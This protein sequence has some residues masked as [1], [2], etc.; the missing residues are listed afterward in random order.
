M[1]HAE[2]FHLSKEMPGAVFICSV[3][4]TFRNDLE[5][6]AFMRM[7]QDS[8]SVQN[9]GHILQHQWFGHLADGVYKLRST[10]SGLKSNAFMYLYVCQSLLKLPENYNWKNLA[11]F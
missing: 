6:P 9:W 7:K 1:L 2:I 5:L 11:P 8:V 10:L 4:I 3:F